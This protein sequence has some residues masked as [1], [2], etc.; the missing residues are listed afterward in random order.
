MAL[1]KDILADKGHDVVTIERTA[2]VTQA[3]Q[4]MTER[5]I[6]A[7][8]VVHDEKVVG[9]ISERDLLSRVLGARLDPEKTP[10]GAVMTWPIAWCRLETSLEECREVM[11]KMRIRHLPVVEA[12]KLAGIISSRDVLAFEITDN[13]RTIE[14]L[15]DYIQGKYR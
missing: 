11:T 6:G 13:L 12:G 1:V 9:I 8:I 15:H 2:S 10:V 4:L 7:L 5:R 3:A 14:Y